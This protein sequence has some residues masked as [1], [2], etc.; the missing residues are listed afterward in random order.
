MLFV[1]LKCIQKEKYIKYENKFSY[2]ETTQGIGRKKD[3]I[4]TWNSI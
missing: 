3:I 1:H 2:G 4:E